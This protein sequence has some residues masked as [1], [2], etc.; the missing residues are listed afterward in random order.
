M[1]NAQKMQISK[2]AIPNQSM[3]GNKSQ[4]EFDKIMMEKERM[5]KENKKLKQQNRVKKIELNQEIPLLDT[6]SYKQ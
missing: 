3:V 4:L 2:H 1:D 6:T 5:I